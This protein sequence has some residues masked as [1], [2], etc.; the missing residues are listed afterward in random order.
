MNDAA[1]LVSR[2][3]TFPDLLAFAAVL[4]ALS[5]L[6]LWAVDVER[7]IV[8]LVG[9]VAIVDFVMW[10]VFRAINRAKRAKAAESTN[11]ATNA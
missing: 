5:A 11:G 10:V 8:L 1:P 2:I 3:T 4:M 7:Q 6:L 9:A